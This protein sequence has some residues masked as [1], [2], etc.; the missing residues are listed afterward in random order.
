MNAWKVWH[1]GS[2]NSL[3]DN[4]H[5]SADFSYFITQPEN[6]RVDTYG[7][8]GSINEVTLCT[9]T[10]IV[11][12]AYSATTDTKIL[13]PEEITK[14]TFAD[15]LCTIFLH[16]DSVGF[17]SMKAAIR[18]Q[19]EQAAFD[20]VRI[21]KPKIRLHTVVPF[22]GVFAF[23]RENSNEIVIMFTEVYICD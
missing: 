16:H 15:E 2:L 1:A 7:F 6:A 21:F 14:A 19:L 10:A 9:E 4:L 22:N 8:H 5:W 23:V 13:P 11:F 18:A 20:D 12:N 3:I 17:K